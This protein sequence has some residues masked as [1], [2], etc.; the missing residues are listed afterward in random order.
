MVQKK[1]DFLELSK[2]ACELPGLVETPRGERDAVQGQTGSR[3]IELDA[4]N[5]PC[6]GNQDMSSF[7]PPR[8]APGHPVELAWSQAS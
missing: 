7:F 2:F 6:H 8:V 5:I 4:V 1:K 3:L